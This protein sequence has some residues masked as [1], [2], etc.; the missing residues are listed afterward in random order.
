[1]NCSVEIWHFK[2]AMQAMH[3]RLV[4]KLQKDISV[5]LFKNYT[6][7][8]RLCSVASGLQGYEL[9]LAG[10]LREY[11]M[12]SIFYQNHTETNDVHKGNEH[13]ILIPKSKFV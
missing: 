13:R 6:K 4:G 9:F 7:K 2:F 1:M 3:N 5:G 12:P 11:Y 8:N 10:D